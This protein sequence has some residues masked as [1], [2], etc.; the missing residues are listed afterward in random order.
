MQHSEDIKEKI[1]DLIP[2]L[3]RFKQNITTTTI[4]GDPEETDRHRGLTWYGHR[5]M[6]AL[7]IPN[8][9]CSTFEKIEELSQK[10]LAKSTITRL[11]DKGEDSKTVARLIERL[12][13]AIIC[14]QVGGCCTPV[15]GIVDR[16]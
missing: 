5:L 13:E 11:V 14:Y 3:G 10:L 9:C 16:E 15:L 2:Q 6:T 8:S 7:S 12:R 4:D 1:E